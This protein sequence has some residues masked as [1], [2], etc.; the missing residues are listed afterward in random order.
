LVFGKLNLC[1]KLAVDRKNYPQQNENSGL[2]SPTKKM[3][4]NIAESKKMRMCLPRV[5]A[6]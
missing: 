1:L 2:V 3:M 5:G 4:P 6:L